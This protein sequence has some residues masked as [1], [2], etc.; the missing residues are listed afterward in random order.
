ML[1]EKAFNWSDDL[2]FGIKNIDDHHI[3]MFKLFKDLIMEMKDDTNDRDKKLKKEFREEAGF[4]R[5]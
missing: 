4:A 2:L 1:L 5:C 3:R